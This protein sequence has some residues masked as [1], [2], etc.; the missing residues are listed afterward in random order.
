MIFQVETKVPR[1]SRQLLEAA[2]HEPCGVSGPAPAAVALHANVGGEEAAAEAL[3]SAMGWSRLRS[4]WGLDG[5]SRLAWL[6]VG[7]GLILL[8]W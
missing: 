4:T 5:W 3:A 7:F 8:R 2:S 1:S 6:V